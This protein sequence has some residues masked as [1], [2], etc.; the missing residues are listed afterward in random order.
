VANQKNERIFRIFKKKK[1]INYCVTVLIFGVAF[2]A[3]WFSN[4]RSSIS[5][6]TVRAGILYAICAAT[7]GG[8]ILHYANWRC[9]ACKKHLG[10]SLNPAKC[11]KCGVRL[12]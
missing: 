10:G 4:N 3:V 9:P 6:D 12:Q 1:I 7:I 11:R 2:F 8:L 5:D